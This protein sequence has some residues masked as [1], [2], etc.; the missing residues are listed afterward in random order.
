MIIRMQKHTLCIASLLLCFLSFAAYPVLA[1]EEGALQLLQRSEADV[2]QELQQVELDIKKD[3]ERLQQ[4]ELELRASSITTALLEDANLELA[5][6]RSRQSGLQTRLKARRSTLTQLAKEISDLESRIQRSPADE[7]GLEQWRTE[8]SDLQQRMQL[9]STL[10]DKIGQLNQRYEIRNAL[11]RQRLNLLQARFELPDLDTTR[12][13]P[14]RIG[15]KLQK[16]VNDLLATASLSRRQSAGLDQDTP[17]DREQRR[18]L[19]MQALVSEEQAE[20]LQM[21]IVRQQVE[22]ILQSLSAL[23]GARSTPVRV[24]KAVLRNTATMQEELD[25][26]QELTTLKLAQFSEQRQM[27]SQ[28]GTIA[29]DAESTVAA[30]LKLIDELIKSAADQQG[31]ISA[32]STRVQASH[33]EYQSTIATQSGA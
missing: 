4:A 8:L 17:R 5:S 9:L 10:I 6:L 1:Q 24:L 30:R 3:R 13:P 25:R 12:L 28:Q 19:E 21:S 2:S 22:R 27:I 16:Q 7:P 26:Q 15:V 11:A 32:L 18:L 20:F 29:S 33:T 31:A 14:G 23:S